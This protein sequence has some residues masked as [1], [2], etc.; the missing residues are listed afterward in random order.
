MDHPERSFHPLATSDQIEHSSSPRA[1][2]DHPEQSSNTRVG[3][4]TKA[5]DPPA[6]TAI[7]SANSASP[8][9][10]KVP[11]GTEN[12]ESLARRLEQEMKDEELARRLSEEETRK[13]RRTSYL[14]RKKNHQ[15]NKPGDHEA[16]N[17]PMDEAAMTRPVPDDGLPSLSRGRSKS[18]YL[19]G[20][21]TSGTKKSRRD[22]GPKNRSRSPVPGKSQ[23]KRDAA[24]PLRSTA[25]VGSMAAHKARPEQARTYTSGVS[26]SGSDDDDVSDPDLDAELAQKMEQEERDA[27]LARQMNIAEVRQVSVYHLNVDANGRR[28]S[29]WTFRRAMSLAIPVVII[30]AALVG[31][32]F[33]FSGG[34]G[35]PSLPGGA[36]PVF[37]NGDPFQGVTPE[38][39]NRWNSRGSGLSLEIL[40]ALDDSWNANFVVAIDE[41]DS[42]TPDALTLRTTRVP[43]DSSCAEVTG[44]LK[45]CNGDYG[46]TKWRGINQVKLSNN[47]IVSSV[48]KL[49]EFYLASSDENQ[50]QYTMC[51]EIGHGFGLPHTD[52]NFYNADLGN[53]MDYTSNPEVNK[54]PA[55][56]NYLFLFDLYGLATR[57]HLEV[58]NVVEMSIPD[59][60]NE[61]MDALVP[62]LDC[63]P[64]DL[65]E[66]AEEY[67]CDL[68]NGFSM[69]F[70]ML[71]AVPNR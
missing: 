66:Y 4:S 5:I 48:A 37:E 33:A 45:V 59:S 39:A 12:D 14:A 42:G 2:A 55:Q 70:S 32:A 30:L 57:R 21:K 16:G 22:N 36:P 44:K 50:R 23:Q 38:K 17:K 56:V 52:E 49:N 68:G 63:D 31:L 28:Q 69:L 10:T 7:L 20:I 26:V 46:D 19:A 15:R 53:C 71:L 64:I 43:V 40:N 11:D 60:V 9:S 18:P 29:A 27:A 25:P 47:Y 51:H 6:S 67:L 35:L 1:T 62:E 58:S 65:N 41:W 13:R 3:A 24:S 61:M 8:T 54:Q 34:N